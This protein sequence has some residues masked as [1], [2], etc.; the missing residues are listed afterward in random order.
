MAQKL[1]PRYMFEE[2]IELAV[3]QPLWD[4]ISCVGKGD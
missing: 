2:G 1:H 4:K 3:V